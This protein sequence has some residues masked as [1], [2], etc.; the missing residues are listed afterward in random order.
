MDKKM[1]KKIDKKQL[2]NLVF[3][4]KKPEE[5]ERFMNEQGAIVPRAK[6]GLTQKQQRRLV[7]EIKRARHLGLLP[8]TQSV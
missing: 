1:D 5:L 8:F 7:V 2:E 6:T 3:S 4:Y